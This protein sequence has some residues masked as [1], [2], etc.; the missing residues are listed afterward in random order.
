MD[1][2]YFLRVV[3]RTAGIRHEYGLEQAEESDADEIADEEVG[4]ENRQRQRHTK[5]HDENVDHP[6]LRIDRA[7]ADYLFAVGDGRGPGVELDVVLDVDDRA[8]RARDHGLRR[9]AREPVN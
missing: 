5:N 1:L 7:D 2:D 9:S 4:I 8:I 6:F 3:P